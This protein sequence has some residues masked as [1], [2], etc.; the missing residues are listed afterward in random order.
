MTLTAFFVI[1]V[2]QT[3]GILPR[4]EGFPPFRVGQARPT[5]L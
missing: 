4:R 1:F 2:L 3:L 5:L